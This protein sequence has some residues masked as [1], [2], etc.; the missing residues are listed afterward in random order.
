MKL[1]VLFKIY[2]AIRIVITDIVNLAFGLLVLKI[3]WLVV[4]NFEV[5]IK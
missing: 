2:K 4:E 3:M 5:I 1:S